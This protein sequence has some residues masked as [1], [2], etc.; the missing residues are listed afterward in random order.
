M[1]THRNILTYAALFGALSGCHV[2]D[3]GEISV[4]CDELDNCDPSPADT[5]LANN[6]GQIFGFALAAY[7]ATNGLLTLEYLED[8]TIVVSKTVNVT[9]T[10][11]G[12]LEYAPTA[13]GFYFSTSTGLI[14]HVSNAGDVTT[15]FSTE[16][17]VTAIESKDSELYAAIGGVIH[18]I[19]EDTLEDTL[20]IDG[21]F[22]DI[23]DLFTGPNNDLYAL[24]YDGE[25]ASI[26]TINADNSTALQSFS[27]L[28][29]GARTVSAFVG[30]EDVI[31]TCSNAGG[32][33][34][35]DELAKGNLIPA[36]FPSQLFDSATTSCGY[37]AMTGSYIIGTE[38]T[39]YRLH[40]DGS[41]ETIATPASGLYISIDY[42]F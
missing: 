35:A 21:D 9:T 38:D 37:D 14:Q 10:P 27:G 36:A 25:S 24:D 28:D 1:T 12:G 29:D 11:G 18:K 22:N 4:S 31:Y 34:I 8:D 32:V 42:V 30:R 6:E 5:G 7:D 26:W 15:I 20:V 3:G 17:E 41:S 13:S 19:P 23:S 33:Y 39:I 16:N 2:F 40:R